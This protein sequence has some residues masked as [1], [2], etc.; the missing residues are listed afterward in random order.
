MQLHERLRVAM[1]TSD[2][3]QRELAQ[4]VGI[5]EAYLSRVLSGKQTAPH[6]LLVRL[7]L[8]LHGLSDTATETNQRPEVAA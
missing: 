4:R 8:A 1:A 6:R 5:D 2:M 3:R 7:V